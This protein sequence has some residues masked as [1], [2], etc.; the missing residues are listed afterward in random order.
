MKPKYWAI[1]VLAALAVILGAAYFAKQPA[2]DLG[3][4]TIHHQAPFITLLKQPVNFTGTQAPKDLPAAHNAFGIDVFKQIEKSDGNSNVF[5]SPTS[6]ALALSMVYNGAVGDTR[7]AMAKTLHFQGLDIGTVDKQSAGLIQSMQNPDPKVQLAIADSV[8]AKQG[9]SFNQSFLDTVADSFGAKAA[10][11]DFNDPQSVQTINSWV[12]DHT[13]GKIPT[14]INQL[15]SDE[16]MYLINAVYF[17]GSWTNAFDPSLTQNGDFHLADGSTAQRLLMQMH[18]KDFQYFEN[19]DFQSIS[20]PYGDNQRLTMN[21]FLPTGNVNDLINQLDQ[22]T[23]DQW[24][25]QYQPMEGDILLPKFKLT[26]QR[27]LASDL[28]SL[29]MGIAFGNGADFSGIGNNLQISEVIHK[30]YVNVDEEGTEAAAVTGV[31]ITATA[32]LAHSKTFYMDVNKP[33][34]FAIRDTQ[35]GEILFM[36]AVQDPPQ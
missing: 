23:W 29:G 11:L 5:I 17:K 20:L 28:S 8:W 31:G 30:T 14:I 18:R 35:T 25:S 34:F 32:V 4:I 33:F 22:K 1:V 21:I 36:G 9:V 26:Y 19:N 7:A 12:S 2:L 13:N 10:V 3:P 15:S 6:I 16:V 24:M 27:E